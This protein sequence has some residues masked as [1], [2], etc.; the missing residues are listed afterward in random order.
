MEPGD[1]PWGMFVVIEDLDGNQIGLVEKKLRC[2]PSN[3]CSIRRLQL[4]EG[5]EQVGAE[6]FC[7]PIVPVG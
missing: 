7:A 1:V 4:A 6:R 5:V 2:N 3:F